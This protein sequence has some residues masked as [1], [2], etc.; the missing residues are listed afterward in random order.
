MK[1]RIMAFMP[2]AVLALFALGFLT[3]CPGPA[4]GT[5][6]PV[7]VQFF[8]YLNAGDSGSAQQVCTERALDQE[9]DR[10]GNAFNHMRDEYDS[11]DNIYTLDKLISDIRGNT[12]EIWSRDNEDLRIILI[13]VGTSWRIDE[14]EFRDGGGRAPDDDRDRENG[15]NADDDR[16][17]RTRN[18]E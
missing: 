13:N 7:V 11:G 2:T 9:M 12:A 17:R 15:D 1:I 18:D 8:E 6:E 4:T 10:G 14:F 16:E 3:G 5:P